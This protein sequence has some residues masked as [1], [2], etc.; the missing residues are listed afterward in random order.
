MN[1]EVQTAE[2]G[3]IAEARDNQ[4]PVT[5]NQMIQYALDKDAGMEKLE[6]L[7]DVKER[8]EADEARKAFH[9]AMASFK[10]NPPT[11][12]KDMVNPQYKSRYTSL[13]NLV[14]TVNTALSDHG[15][16]ARW[17]FD[18]GENQISVTCI[19]S[20]YMGHSERVTLTGPPDTSGS[21]NPIQQIKST[22]TYLKA[23][24][25][26]AVTGIASREANQ[27]DDGG[28][29]SGDDAGPISEEQAN[30]LLTLMDEIGG[31][32]KIRFCRYYKLDQVADLPAAK[33]EDAK[34]ALQAKRQK[35]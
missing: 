6:K 1:Q 11:V 33:F 23:A 25:F 10:K 16:D 19:L 28:A 34:K 4:P 3:Q 30:E 17:E 5:P 32:T 18:Q 7:L 12:I 31:E 2:T 15:L 9:E 22:T 24:T 14:N 8:W 29:A 13:A 21:K 26:E 27:D 20:H 35:Q